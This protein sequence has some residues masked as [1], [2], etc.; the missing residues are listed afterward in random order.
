MK[1]SKY[2]PGL[3]WKILKMITYHAT[4]PFL[5]YLPFVYCSSRTAWI[6]LVFISEVS[7]CPLHLSQ[8]KTLHR[9]SIRALKRH[10][11]EHDLISLHMPWERDSWGVVGGS[12]QT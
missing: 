4:L 9:P 2:K 8:L 12:G 1:K 11:G 7:D 10:L 3:K 6:T 5:N